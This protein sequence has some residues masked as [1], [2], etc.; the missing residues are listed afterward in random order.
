MGVDARFQAMDHETLLARARETLR[1][2]FGY[3]DFRPGQDEAVSAVLAGRDAVVILPTGGGKS[4]CFQ[5]PALMLPGI[6]VVVSPLI[7]LMK[8]Q[9][10]GLTARG[11]PAALKATLA[12]GRAA[13]DA[14]RLDEARRRAD[15]VLRERPDAVQAH[16]LRA[17]VHCAAQDLGNVQASLRNI[18]K[19]Q[20]AVVVRAC[21]RAGIDL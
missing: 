2:S 18:P 7:S 10:D 17:L 20:Q 9:V 1:A 19:R 13:L 21:R 6:T 5:V 14:G 15:A 12:Q 3:A 8:D 4:M 16:I 11:L